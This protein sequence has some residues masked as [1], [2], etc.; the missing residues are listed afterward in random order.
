MSVG[1]MKRRTSQR[2]FL[3]CWLAIF[4]RIITIVGLIATPIVILNYEIWELLYVAL[5]GIFAIVMA[6]YIGFA[7]VLRCPRCGNRFL[8]EP[9]GAKHPAARRAEHLDYWGTVVW[10]VVRGQ[11]FTCMH[12]GI[13][14]H[15]GS[16]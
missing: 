7:F 16:A 2:L 12:C 3:A 14:Y 10:N 4:A 9:S 15:K 11:E 6:V 5:L 8:V 13:L 1:I